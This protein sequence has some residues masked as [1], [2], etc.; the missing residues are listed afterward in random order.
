MRSFAACATTS[1]AGEL[2]WDQG[3]F[4][5]IGAVCAAGKV[6][7]LDRHAMGQAISLATVPNVP[8][9]VTRG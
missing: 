3:I 9:G 6:M 8:L 5:V 4:S 1:L 2:G 7:G